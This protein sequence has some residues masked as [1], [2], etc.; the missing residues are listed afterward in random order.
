M[1]TETKVIKTK[2]GLLQLA[3]QLTQ[4]LPGI[5]AFRLQQVLLLPFQGTR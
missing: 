5:Q 1:N 4:R 3:E 2:V